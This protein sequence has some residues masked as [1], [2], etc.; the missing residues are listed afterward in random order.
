V[1]LHKR[2]ARLEAQRGG[3]VAGPSIIFFRDGATGETSAALVIGGRNLSREVGE[4]PDAFELRAM[5]EIP[6]S[7]Q[8]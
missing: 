6:S 7:K 3:A 5:A 2:L 8:H 4:T 1:T